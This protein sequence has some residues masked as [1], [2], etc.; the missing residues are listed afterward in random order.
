MLKFPLPIVLPA[1][2]KVTVTQPFGVT[3]NTLEPIG[4]NG[5]PHFHYGI[6]L[7]WG[8]D[9]VIFGTP[10]VLPE[11]AT[12]SSYVLPPGNVNQPTPYVMFNF[13]GA[14]G[15]KYTMELAHCS[16]IFLGAQYGKGK[17]VALA[18]NYGLVAPTPTIADPFAGSHLH[19]GLQID[20][21]YVDPAEYFD[22][23]QFTVGPKRD[24]SNCVPRINWACQQVEA[25]LQAL[26]SAK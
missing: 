21:K 16:A 19:L 6:D 2:T 3:A 11:V 8:P 13:T 17:I 24:P 15:T 10:L 7:V 4:P 22:V 23:T 12:E 9:N 14:S 20:G 5:E 25:E 18:G 26:V 1:G